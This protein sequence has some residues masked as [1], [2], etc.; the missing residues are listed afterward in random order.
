MAIVKIIGPLENSY[1]VLFLKVILLV[2][3]VI[4]WVQHRF[5]IG[6]TIL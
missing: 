1:K 4:F 6:Y 3:M 5:F 2:L